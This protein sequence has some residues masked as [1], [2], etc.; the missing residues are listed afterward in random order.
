MRRISCLLSI[1]LLAAALSACG[2]KGEL[3]KP[4][5]EPANPAPTSD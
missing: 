5:P 1:L 4:T 3:V 2:A